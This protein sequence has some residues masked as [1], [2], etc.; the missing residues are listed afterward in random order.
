MG[1]LNAVMDQQHLYKC[2]GT[3]VGHKVS[4]SPAYYRKLYSVVV[5]IVK[6][7]CM[8]AVCVCIGSSVGTGTE[9]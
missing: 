3:F 9:Q 5:Y 6:V 1:V 7:C 2:Q 4:L 8:L